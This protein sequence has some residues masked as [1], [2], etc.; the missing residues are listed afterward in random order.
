MKKQLLALLTIVVYMLLKT[1]LTVTALTYALISS[2]MEG[3]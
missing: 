2:R 3:G 1:V